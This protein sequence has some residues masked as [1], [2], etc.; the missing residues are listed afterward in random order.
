MIKN[1]NI[2]ETAELGFDPDCDC[3][4][5]ERLRMEAI[6]QDTDDECDCYTRY[7][8]ERNLLNAV[9]QDDMEDEWDGDEADDEDH[10]WES[11][12]DVIM[13]QWD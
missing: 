11:E 6:W 4:R 10:Y 1:I 13:A 3:Y 9:W 5:C 8:Y 7:N 2:V 12:G